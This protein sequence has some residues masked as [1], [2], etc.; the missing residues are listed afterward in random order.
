[1]TTL[2]VRLPA[3][4]DPVAPASWWRVDD[5]GRIVARGVTPP[6][7]WPAADPVQAVMAAAD[8]R[9]V[10]LALPP[11]PA[12]RLRTAAAFALEDQLAAPVESMHLAV[13]ASAGGAPAMARV[14]DRDAIAWLA[15][16]RPAIERV[17]AEPDLVVSDGA[18]HW[19]IGTD[20]AGFVRRPDGSAFATDSAESDALPAALAAALARAPRQGARV[21][22]DADVDTA[23]L[24]AWS[25]ASGVTFA[26][27]TPWMLERVPASAWAAAPDLRTGHGVSDAGSRPSLRAFGPAIA[28]VL[29]AVTLHFIATAGVWAHDRYV[30][31]RADRD[32]VALARDAGLGTVPDARAAESLLA[33]RAASALHAEARGADGDALPTLARAAGPLAALPAGS[34]RKLTVAERRLVA[35]LGALDEARL[36]RLV[37][38]LASAGLATV[39]APIAGGVR[40]SATVG[41]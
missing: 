5:T 14:V 1:M 24:A 6:S 39:T 29:A 27:G 19:C 23:R 34:V 33:R 16:H 36:A 41:P 13:T 8:V 25:R 38:D 26:R 12:S 35:D 15:A 30:A 2:R 18:W 3:P 32:V 37:Q 11:M 9:I 7:A 20:G 21:I 22:V 4:F 17:V 31:W 28:L 10:A 40:L